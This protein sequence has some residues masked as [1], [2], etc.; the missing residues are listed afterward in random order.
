MSRAR[1]AFYGAGH[2]GRQVYHH[3]RHHCSE[4]AEVIG[5]FDDTRAAG[6]EVMDGLP[7]LGPLAGAAPAFGPQSVQIVF[8]I[9]YA[10]MRQRRA[11]LERVLAAGYRLFSVVHPRAVVEPGAR[12]G[13]GCIVLAGAVVDQQVSVGPACFIDIGVRLTAG[14]TVGS[15]NYFSTGT[16]TGSRVRIGDDC[17]FGMDCTITTDVQMG[18]HLFVNAKTLVPRNVGDNLKLVEM[19]KSRELPLGSAPKTT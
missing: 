17:F 7:T 15:N 1:V 14:T 4:T 8:T 12:L 19:H 10:D 2:L 11:A 3:V 18:S 13:E 9:G 6:L 5:F 16:A